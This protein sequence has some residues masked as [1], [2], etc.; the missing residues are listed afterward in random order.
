MKNI[1]LEEFSPVCPIQAFVEEY[2]DCVY[3]YLWNYPGEEY[4][5]VRAC[6]VR[7]Y[8]PAP[9][10]LDVEAMGHG[11]APMLPRDCCAHPDGAERLDPEQLAVVWFEEGDA[12]ALLYRDEIVSVIPGWAGSSADEHSY[13]GYA[14][15]CIG[16]SN[17][18]FPLGTPDSNALFRR[19]ELAKQFWQSWDEHTW[20][21]L[22]QQYL[23]AIESGLGPVTN[24]YAIDGGNW[25]PRAMV[26]VEKGD[27]TY[28][29]TLGTSILPQPK[30][31][32]YTE[33]PELLRRFEFAFACDSR[34]LAEQ[35]KPMLQYISGQANLPWTYLTFVANGHT[36][37]CGEIGLS[38]E[39]FTA[40]ALAQPPHAPAIALPQIGGD[41][42]NLLWMIP[43]TEEERHYAE[44]EGTERLFERASAPEE[45]IFNGEA[46]FSL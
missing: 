3:F 46:K 39:R 45:W 14:R 37:P 13:P 17:L 9:E 28:V 22:Q 44:E 8:G 31:E 40:V 11:R 10:A 41:P 7:N 23:E 27:V 2:E 15:D 21:G 32:Q 1:I 38:H 34:W 19:I 6:W 5:S 43:I 36:I 24:Y 30:V 35:G 18:C 12:A 16:E 25:P 20:T 4:A 26:T 42:V 29:V 33:T